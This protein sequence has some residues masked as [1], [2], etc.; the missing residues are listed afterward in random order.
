MRN[1]PSVVQAIGSILLMYIFQSLIVGAVVSGLW[2]VFLQNRLG[3][4][5]NFF[6]WF[7]II[8][9]FN[10]IRLDITKFIDPNYKD[11]DEV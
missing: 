5:M 6:H 2:I 1:R 3:F 10:L 8:M 4:D 11:N 9:I 7:A